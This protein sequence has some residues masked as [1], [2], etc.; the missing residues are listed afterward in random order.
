L[1]FD[2]LTQIFGLPPW[3]RL[4]GITITPL[5]GIRSFKRCPE[6]TIPVAMN[7]WWEAMRTFS[8]HH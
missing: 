7:A 1:D 6:R 3:K 4:T 8:S 5:L 2:R